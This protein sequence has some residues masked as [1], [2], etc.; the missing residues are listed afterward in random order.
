[1][2]DDD[3]YSVS[4]GDDDWPVADIVYEGVQ[5]ASMTGPLPAGVLTVGTSSLLR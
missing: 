2:T 5:W 1:M 3:I 4:V